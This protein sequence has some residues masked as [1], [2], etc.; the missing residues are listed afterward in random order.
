MTKGGDGP[1][2]SGEVSV[3]IAAGRPRDR[4]RTL[5]RADGG[6][7]AARDPRGGGWREL[8]DVRVRFAQAPALLYWRESLAAVPPAELRSQGQRRCRVNRRAE[9]VIRPPRAKNRVLVVTI[10]PDRSALSSGRCCGPSP[11]PPARRR[12]RRSGPRGDGSA[13]RRTGLGWHSR[14]ASSSNLPVP[15]G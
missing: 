15:V 8:A 12:W 11:V 4:L 2:I 10:C 9:R 1:G 3:C 5:G 14:P 6:E 13:R 7:D